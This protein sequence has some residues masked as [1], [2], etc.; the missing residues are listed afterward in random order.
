[1]SK[2]NKMK[3]AQEPSELIIVSMGINLVRTHSQSAIVS[4]GHG[5]SLG[6]T[7]DTSFRAVFFQTV[8]GIDL[9]EKLVKM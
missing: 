4:F 3:Q 8:L 6:W 9:P 5:L 1:M 2:Q 7:E